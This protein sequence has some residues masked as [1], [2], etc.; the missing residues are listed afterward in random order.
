MGFS[1]LQTPQVAERVAQQPA[2]AGT[3]LK[4][5]KPSVSWPVCSSA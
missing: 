5:E 2:D 4:L 3:A 1:S